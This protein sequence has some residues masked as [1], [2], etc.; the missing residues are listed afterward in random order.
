MLEDHRGSARLP[1]SFFFSFSMDLLQLLAHRDDCY[2]VDSIN[3]TATIPASGDATPSPPLVDSLVGYIACRTL[4]S[5]ALAD[6]NSIWDILGSDISRWP[7]CTS[8]TLQA[9]GEERTLVPAVECRLR[10]IRMA[11][12]TVRLE[13]APDSDL[14]NP[15]CRADGLCREVVALRNKLC[16]SS[17]LP[18]I[19]RLLKLRR[20]EADEGLLP[21]RGLDVVVIVTAKAIV[22]EC[23]HLIRSLFYDAT[24]IILGL[25]EQTLLTSPALENN[26]TLDFEVSHYGAL[27]AVKF[28]CPTDDGA[29]AAAS[30]LFTGH[31]G[32]GRLLQ[33]EPSTVAYIATKARAGT[34]PSVK[35]FFMPHST[36]PVF[37]YSFPLSEL[38]PG[39]WD[40]SAAAEDA[41]KTQRARKFDGV[42]VDCIRV[43]GL[44]S[45]NTDPNL[46]LRGYGPPR[47]CFC[48]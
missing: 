41:P 14:F 37:G 20:I 12:A 34:F 45:A 48:G 29:L 4:R 31:I 28:V 22:R 40:G 27:G 16:I 8:S 21:G 18:H 35:R 10:E 1:L 11:L 17:F 47:R 7:R 13:F 42:Y 30:V 26:Y 5:L 2:C 38:D 32:R 23:R 9:I 39:E 25:P 19:E 33:L 15:G 44:A 43:S 36:I 46:K 24:S 3:N 6:E